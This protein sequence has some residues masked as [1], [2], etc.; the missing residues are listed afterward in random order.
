M[1]PRQWADWLREYASSTHSR[2][3]AGNNLRKFT[4]AGRIMETDEGVAAAVP[5]SWCDFGALGNDC[6]LF[7][8][9]D[10][11]GRCGY[12]CRMA[13]SNCGALLAPPFL[14]LPT[15]E[16]QIAPL[17]EKSVTWTTKLATELAAER[18][19]RDTEF[20]NKLA[21]IN[22]DFE[23]KQAAIAE[24]HEAKQAASLKRATAGIR[25]FFATEH[26]ITTEFAN[27]LAARRQGIE[28]G[29]ATQ[30][31]EFANKLAAIKQRFA[32]EQDTKMTEFVNKSEAMR[33]GFVADRATRITE[34]VNELAAIRQSFVAELAAVRMKHEK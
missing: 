28:V 18:A 5:C 16:E 15:P 17:S 9:Q 25:E 22:E 1:P 6:R 13:K 8:N 29:Q 24:L 3:A 27:E 33:Q 19:T 10:K 26:D 30:A 32:A 2:K 12:C 7:A 11:G 23:A 31:K 4:A 34:H 21:A 20:A 14:P